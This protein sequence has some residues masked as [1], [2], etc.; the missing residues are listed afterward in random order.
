MMWNRTG[1][2]YGSLTNTLRLCKGGLVAYT[3]RCHH[4]YL[5]AAFHDHPRGL[6][7]NFVMFVC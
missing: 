3:A 1:D 6:H 2:F 7:G 4:H 5:L